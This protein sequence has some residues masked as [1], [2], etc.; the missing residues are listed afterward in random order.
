MPILSLAALTILDA[1]PIGLVKAAHAA[2]FSHAGIRLQPLLATDPVIVGDRA[3]EAE[4]E[5]LL[6]ETGV[7]PLEIGVFPI[8]PG[9][10][11][12]DYGPV[13]SFSHRIG[14]QFITCPIE[15]PDPVSRMASFQR[16]CDLAISCGLEALVEFNPYS[17]CRSLAEAAELVVA[18]E[19]ENARLLIDVLHLSRSGGSPADLATIPPDLI[20]LVHLCDAPPPPPQTRSI[21]ELRQESR[22]ARL[23]PGEGSLWLEELLAK[24]PAGTPLSVEAPSAAHRHL[25]PEDRAKQAMAA[26]RQL[27]DRLQIA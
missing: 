27:L 5:S 24:L 18:S 22:T 4:M 25:P 2:G 19:R 23:Y 21:A 13:L 17:A 9:H 14:A 1:G 15:D 3:R 16:L 8:K 6:R 11:V 10:N 26:T 12:D 7:R 20:A